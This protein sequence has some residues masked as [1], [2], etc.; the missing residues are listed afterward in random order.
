MKRMNQLLLLMFCVGIF[1]VTQV[2]AQPK[3]TAT[4]KAATSTTSADPRVAKA[5]N[6]TK[7]KFEVD[8]D[9]EYKVTFGI[10]EIRSQV[11]FVS[12]TT[13]KIYDFEM[14][15]VYSFA[16][17]SETPFPQE[18]TNR[19]L[20]Q[21]MENVSAW[22]VIKVSN[23]YAIVNIAYIPADADGK[24]LSAAIQSV[25]LLADELEAQMSKEDKL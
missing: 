5:L 15:G 20:A 7:T 8:E 17:F 10:G 24:R 18:I 25:M 16:A 19:L 2:I 23:A 22:A 1:A 3:K 14:R 11:T 13:D 21:N 4:K 12:S 6:Q 9:G